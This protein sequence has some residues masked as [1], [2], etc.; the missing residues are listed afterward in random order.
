MGGLSRP[1]PTLRG[2]Q[3]GGE[4]ERGRKEEEGKG[5]REKRGEDGRGRGEGEGMR[6]REGR[7]TAMLAELGSGGLVLFGG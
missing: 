4:R 7:E 1:L 3:Q 2:Q 6:K 5:K